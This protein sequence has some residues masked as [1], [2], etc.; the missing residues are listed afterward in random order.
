MGQRELE[1]DEHRRGQGRELD[2]AL[3]AAARTRRSSASATA[4]TRE[5]R[6]DEPEVGDP[7]CVVL[8]PAPERERRVA[9]R[10]GSRPCGPRT[11]AARPRARA[12]AGGS[13][14][15]ATAVAANASAKRSSPSRV[16]RRVAR[17]ERRQR[18]APR[19]SPS[20]R[21][22]PPHPRAHADDASQKPKTRSAGMIVSF[23]FAFSAYAVNGYADPGE[24][25]DQPRAARPRSEARRARARGWSG[26]R[27]AID[28]AC[29]AGS[30]SHFP[31]HPKTSTAGT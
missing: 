28:V 6:L 23:V 2:R 15:N 11:S 5:H 25:E 16:E 22:R 13:R 19:T 17:P 4:S 20:L 8:A 21:A 3:L 24:R 1:R 18:A 30:E 7:L 29:A 10:P 26:G 12:R 9:R 31:L 14:P 27:S